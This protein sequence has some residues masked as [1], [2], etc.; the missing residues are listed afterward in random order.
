VSL[1]IPTATLVSFLLAMVRAGAWLAISPPF[2]SRVIPVRVKTLLAAAIGLAVTPSLAATAPAPEVAAIVSSAVEQVVVGVALG[3]LTSLVFAAVEAAGSLIDLFGGF[4]LSSAYDPLMLN[5]N[6][7]F[8]R[9]YSLVALTLL[10]VSD[11]HLLV[12][13][14]FARSYDLLPLDASLSLSTLDRV[15]TSGLT[16]MFLSALQIAGPLIA[17]L[18]L[19]DIGLGLLSRVAP[20]LN[21]FSLGF[22]AKILLTLVLA[23]MTFTLLPATVNGLV[24]SAV[25]LVVG[26]AGQ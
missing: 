14:G 22:P 4:S 24:D 20:A 10:F 11:G 1:A 9:L 18:F 13:A 15:L 19:T 26:V 21:A 8:G 17:V 12:V 25:R 3:F 5:Q 16:T 2:S 6:A 23:G 7:V